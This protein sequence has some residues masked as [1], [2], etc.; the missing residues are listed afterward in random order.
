MFLDCR[1]NTG[2]IESID[3][4]LNLQ[5]T[6]GF[7]RSF[8]YDVYYLCWYKDLCTNLVGRV[9]DEFLIFAHQDYKKT[10]KLTWLAETT[11]APLVPALCIYFD[12]IISKPVLSKDD[13][14]KNFVN[15]DT[16]VC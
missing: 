12:N 11:K 1:N 2:E 14:F 5:N 7:Y 8:S 15:K 3:A 6:V 13:D 9:E 10:Q 16:K 4:E